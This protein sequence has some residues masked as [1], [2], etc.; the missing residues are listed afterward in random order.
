MSND[1]DKIYAVTRHTESRNRDH[2]PKTGKILRSPVGAMG[3]MQVMPSTA[4]DPGHG[5]KP[6]NGRDLN[7]LARVGEQLLRALSKRYNGDMAKAWA[8]Y[9]WGAGR[10]DNLVRKHGDNWF[11][12]KMPEETRNY[13]R[14]NMRMLGGQV[15]ASASR[16]PSSPQPI[17]PDRTSPDY[18]L[19]GSS[20]PSAK[21]PQRSDPNY[22]LGGEPD[23]PQDANPRPP[24]APDRTS[25]DYWLGGQATGTT[26]RL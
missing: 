23:Q 12:G 14:Q 24:E 11:S 1:W 20:R 5:I 4:R 7:D 22:W 15:P 25:P 10:V 6:W 13:V 2:D 19:G 3:R 18:W 16:A 21:V 17:G 8:A 9:N 26:P